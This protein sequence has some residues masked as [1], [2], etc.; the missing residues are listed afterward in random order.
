MTAATWVLVLVWAAMVAALAFGHGWWPVGVGVHAAL[1]VV[2]VV[3][4]AYMLVLCVA[5]MARTSC[6]KEEEYPP[7][8]HE[9]EYLIVECLR[10]GPYS[11]DEI[12]EHVRAHGAGGA[13]CAGYADDHIE[14]ILLMLERT[15][16]VKYMPSVGL[17]KLA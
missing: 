2:T 12:V 15:H 1:M 3:T 9:A 6:K 8:K 16:Q 14:S 5:V 13:D 7:M 11:F 4:V 10:R 17:Y